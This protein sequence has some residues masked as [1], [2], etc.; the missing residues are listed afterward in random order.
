MFLY[1]NNESAYIIRNELLLNYYAHIF[2][3]GHQ[4][5]IACLLYTSTS[6]V[7]ANRETTRTADFRRQYSSVNS[8]LNLFPIMRS[9]KKLYFDFQIIISAQRCV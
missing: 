9:F 8:L 6:A 7:A 5:F 1:F 2:S 4:L 3:L